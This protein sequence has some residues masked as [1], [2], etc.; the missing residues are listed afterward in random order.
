[1]AGISDFAHKLT[2][3]LTACNLSRGRLAQSIGIDKSVVSRWASGVQAPTDHNLALL[4]EVVGRH[5]AGFS[6]ADWELASQTFAARL[7]LYDA[8]AAA[9]RTLALPDRPSIAVLPFTNMS[10]DPEQEYFADGMVDEITTALGR[11]RWLFVIA[12]NSSFTYKGKFVNVKQV[13]HDLGVRYVL[14]GSVRKA[15]S[16]VRITAQ[17]IDAGSG[18]HLW[19]D[20]FDG[21]LDDIFDLHDRV[22][23]EVAG[24]VEPNLREAEINRSLRKPTTSL[25]AY[26]LYMRG[27]AA[28]RD[29]SIDSL[30]VSLELTRQAID[31][32]PHFARALA[33]R[34]L[35]IQHLQSGKTDDPDAMAEALGLAHAALAASRDDWEAASIAGTVIS[36]MGGS[37]ETALSASQRALAL[38]PN[39][40]LALMHNGW[41]QCIAGN[42]AASIDPFMR[43][44]R[45]S[46]RDPFGG[47][48]EAGLGVAYRDLGRPQE[49]L[50]WAQ[51]AM[52]SLPL[53]ASGYRTAAVALVDLG[54]IDDAKE[55]IALLLKA[56]PQDHI[57]PDFVRR[58][59]RNEA[60]ADAWIA[61]LRMAGLPD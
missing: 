4:T 22:A 53:L 38:N 20:K 34:A 18:M 33:L 27:L 49:A 56:R 26:D 19:A 51:R 37:I 40:Y 11:L 45:L 17:L 13:G 47:F 55:R 12:R 29:L 60:T 21:A 2:L 43:A 10:G 44:L 52:M 41:I 32:D 59:N 42:P 28:F 58:H 5:Q 3:V 15:A 54:R 16:R 7:G 36:S 39:G 8:R 35:C 6:R 48:C 30:R 31:L 25:D 23:R 9:E 57:R 1:M 46:P 61:A 24:A 14:E 50:D